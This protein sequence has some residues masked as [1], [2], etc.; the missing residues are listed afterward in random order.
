MT[1]NTKVHVVVNQEPHGKATEALIVVSQTVF[2]IVLF[3]II[4]SYLLDGFGIMNSPESVRKNG[5]QIAAIYFSIIVTIGLIM[6]PLYH[7]EYAI[8]VIIGV[9]LGISF[10][11]YRDITRTLNGEPL[12]QLSPTPPSKRS[13]SPSS[14]KDDP[15]RLSKPIIG[16]SGLE[17]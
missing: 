6:I 1:S 3:I 17:F 9:V 15:P 13:D 8:L 11:I 7:Y 10:C 16:N 5:L 4:K 12:D 2:F 14:K